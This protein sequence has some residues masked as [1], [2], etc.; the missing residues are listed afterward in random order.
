MTATRQYSRLTDIRRA[1]NIGVSA[2]CFLTITAGP[3]AADSGL[4]DRSIRGNWGFSALGTIVPPAFPE[5]T[6]AAAVGTIQFDG[7]GACFFSDTINIGGLSAS[8]NSSS[9]SYSVNPDGSGIIL[10]S[11]DGDPGPTPLSFVVVDR[12][13]E[14]QFIRTDLGVARGTAKRIRRAFD[15]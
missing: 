9:C 2:L 3:T 13:R 6:P 5:P 10:V 1:L 4:S 11:F 7:I 8:R 14:I 15:N 12:A